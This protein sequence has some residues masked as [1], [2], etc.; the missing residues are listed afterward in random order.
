METD[1]HRLPGHRMVHHFRTRSGERL[2]VLH[3]GSGRS[4]LVYGTADPDAPERSIA[5]DG[6]EAD[7]LAELLHGEGIRERLDRIERRIEE[8]AC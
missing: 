7:H 5:L 6:D 8:L 1:S 4:L 2:A 3:A